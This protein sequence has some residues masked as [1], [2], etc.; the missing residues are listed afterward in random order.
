MDDETVGQW[1]FHNNTTIHQYWAIPRMSEHLFAM[2][3]ARAAYLKQKELAKDTKEAKD[4]AKGNAAP[5]QRPEHTAPAERFCEL[6]DV[7]KFVTVSGK[8][9]TQTTCSRYRCTFK[10]I[11]NSMHIVAGTEPILR[12]TH[13]MPRDDAPDE[14]Q[15]KRQRHE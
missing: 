4:G 5:P 14:P 6:T 12:V 15:A 10:A 2:L 1:V 3:Q 11:T 13:D 8:F 9:G 7:N